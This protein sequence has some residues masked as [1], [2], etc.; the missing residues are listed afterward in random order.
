MFFQANCSAVSVGTTTEANNMVQAGQQK[1]LEAPFSA[2]E[3]DYAFYARTE[4][5]APFFYPFLRIEPSGGVSVINFK[6][7]V[8]NR[9]FAM[10]V[11]NTTCKPDVSYKFKVNRVSIYR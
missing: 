10:Y 8:V 3:T 4:D 5:N 9:S 1:T 6:H 2:L 11:F 7:D